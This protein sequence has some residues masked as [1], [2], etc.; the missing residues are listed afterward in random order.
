MGDLIGSGAVGRICNRRHSIIIVNHH[1]RIIY[2]LVLGAELCLFIIYSVI[3]RCRRCLFSVCMVNSHG[4]EFSTGKGCTVYG[5]WIFCGTK[6][7]APA[8]TSDC[9]PWVS[10]LMDRGDRQSHPLDSDMWGT[11]RQGDGQGF[12]LRGAGVFPSLWRGGAWTAIFDCRL[13]NFFSESLV[14]GSV[15]APL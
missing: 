15:Y 10:I 2:F 9:S 4:R 3:A 12:Q 8:F 5:G 1:S 11:V 13:A 6:N 14:M 7:F